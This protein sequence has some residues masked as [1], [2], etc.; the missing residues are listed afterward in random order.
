MEMHSSHSQ[1]REPRTGIMNRHE[2]WQGT[3]ATHKLE[4][5]EHHEQA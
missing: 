5:Q 4:S 3:V 1:P 2:L